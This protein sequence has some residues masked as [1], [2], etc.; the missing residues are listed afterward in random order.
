MQANTNLH[1]EPMK[2]QEVATISVNNI[3]HPCRYVSLFTHTEDTTRIICNKKQQ[4][5]GNTKI[6]SMQFMSWLYSR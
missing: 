6:P 1:W 5:K 4:K 2:H 3:V